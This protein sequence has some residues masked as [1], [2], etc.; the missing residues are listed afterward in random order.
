MQLF[1]PSDVQEDDASPAAMEH[2]IP[3]NNAICEGERSFALRFFFSVFGGERF[4]FL[5]FFLIKLL[6]KAQFNLIPPACFH[7]F[8]SSPFSL[9]Y[10]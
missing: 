9:K 4:L 2:A 8:Y 6:S 10:K 5:V 3:G 7:Y 1:Y